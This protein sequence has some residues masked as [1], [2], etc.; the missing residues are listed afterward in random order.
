MVETEIGAAA[1]RKAQTILGEILWPSQRHRISEIR[2]KPEMQVVDMACGAGACSRGLIELL[3][4]GSTVLSFDFDPVNIHTTRKSA[5]QVSSDCKHLL[6]NTRFEESDV[7][8]EV[9][10]VVGTIILDDLDRVRSMIEKASEFLKPGGTLV[11]DFIDLSKCQGFPGSYAL[12]RYNDYMRLYQQE[13]G[14]EMVVAGIKSLFNESWFAH[15]SVEMTT[16]RFLG[17]SERQLPALLLEYLAPFI[18]DGDINS[19]LEIQAIISELRHLA[20]SP[21]VLISAPTSF[22]VAAMKISNSEAQS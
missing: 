14:F 1:R 18:I 4:S 21:Q 22:Q 2:R 3:N 15:V 12:D 20:G 8:S 13:L 17:S 16:P 6:I 11:L 10:L 7:D 5:G 19:E 9:D